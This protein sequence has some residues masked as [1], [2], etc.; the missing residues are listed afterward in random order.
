MNIKGKA[1]KGKEV[2]KTSDRVMYGR[3]S[4][5]NCFALI[6]MG[7]ECLAQGGCLLEMERWIDGW[8]EGGRDR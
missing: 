5:P 6:M 8:I 1:K 4:N 3:G 2:S 7:T